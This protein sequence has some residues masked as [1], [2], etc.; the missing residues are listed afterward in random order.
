MEL[1]KARSGIHSFSNPTE[2][3]GRLFGNEVSGPNHSLPS[4]IDLDPLPLRNF[5]QQHERSRVYCPYPL[6]S[7]PFTVPTVYC[8]CRLLSLPFTNPTVYCPY[9]LLSLPFTVPAVYCPYR[10]LSQPLLSPPLG[11]HSLF[12]PNKISCPFDPSATHSVR[13]THLKF[14]DSIT[15]PPAFSAPRVSTCVSR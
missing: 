14:I 4:D 8:P 2:F 11:L 13:S 12:F 15:A 10:L 5:A 9:R 3:Y 6:L 1:F 7:L